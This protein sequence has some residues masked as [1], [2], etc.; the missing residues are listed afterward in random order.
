MSVP[1]PSVP[2]STVAVPN[3]T[4]QYVNVAVT[5]GTMTNVSVN[6]VTVGAGA[7]N[8]SVPPGGVIAMTYTVAPTWAWT[9]PPATSYSP[10]YSASNLLAEGAGYN[11]DTILPYPGH[12]TGGFPGLATGV[13]N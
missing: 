6:G 10:G 12:A 4:G 1:T 2:A 3:Q 8:Y 5:G 11:P 7:G 9:N 13:S